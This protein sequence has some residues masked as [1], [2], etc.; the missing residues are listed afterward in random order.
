MVKDQRYNLIKPMIEH[1]RIEDLKDIFK[2][3]P[4]TV[5]AKDL[6]IN[7]NRF[8]DLLKTPKNLRVY[9]LVRLADLCGITLRQIFDLITT[10]LERE[11]DRSEK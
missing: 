2:Y 8:S 11:K 10:E 3:I 7:N 5:V 9:D 1:D 4:K 6:G